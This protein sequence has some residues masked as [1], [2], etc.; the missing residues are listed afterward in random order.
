ML[1]T[2]IEEPQLSADHGG[3]SVVPER[4]ATHSTP[5]TSD[6]HFHSPLILSGTS[7]QSHV[8]VSTVGSGV[9][10]RG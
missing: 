8:S 4:V 3:F 6:T 5:E 2:L 9:C 7:C 10:V 1:L